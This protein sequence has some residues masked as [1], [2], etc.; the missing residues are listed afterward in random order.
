MGQIRAIAATA[1]AGAMVVVGAVQAEGAA[2]DPRVSDGHKVAASPVQ[3]PAAT[4]AYWTDARLAAD[5]DPVPAVGT[6]VPRPHAPVRHEPVRHEP[7]RTHEDRQQADER[8]REAR[9]DGR[10]DGVR[11]VRANP[12]ETQQVRRALD[13]VQGLK[14]RKTREVLATRGTRPRAFVAGETHAP[15][16]VKTRVLTKG[17]DSRGYARWPTPYSAEVRSR[18]TGKLFFHDETTDADAFCSASVVRSH[19]RSVILTSA[20]CLVSRQGTWNS[21]ILFIP[22]FRESGGRVERP[23]G[24]WAATQAFV[25]RR[26]LEPGAGFNQDIGLVALAPD[27]H[28]HRIQDVVGA[29]TPFLSRTGER[30]PP[31]TNLGY[32]AGGPY[33]GGL[34]YRCDALVF[35]DNNRDSN[36]LLTTR[37]CGVARGNDGGPW[38]TRFPKGPPPPRPEPVWWVEEKGFPGRAGDCRMAAPPRH[39]PWH[40]I[41]VVSFGETDPRRSFAVRLHATTYGILAGP[42]DRAG[43]RAAGQDHRLADPVSAP[44]GRN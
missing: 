27:S 8:G 22:A 16:P 12:R 37:N 40:V 3:D 25:P 15:N 9:E 20:H 5:N 36:S 41:A 44:C 42:A 10:P 11:Q 34:L 14:E 39:N 23:L 17:G 28:G 19:S 43:L 29:F 33:T 18:I 6:S 35:D 26:F 4:L 2:R 30:F 21:R 7:N 24:R 32:P 13:R 1:L 31:V 38:I